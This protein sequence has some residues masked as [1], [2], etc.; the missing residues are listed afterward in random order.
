MNDDN[1]V[2]IDKYVSPGY[3]QQ[4]REARRVLEKNIRQLLEQVGLFI[5]LF[6][7]VNDI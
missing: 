6:I 3:V 1:F 5:Y 2:L 4:G 7:F